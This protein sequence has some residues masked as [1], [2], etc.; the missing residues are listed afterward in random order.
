VSGLV[1]GM[2]NY[3]IID[4]LDSSGNQRD[5]VTYKYNVPSST[6]ATKLSVEGGT[7]KESCENGMFFLFPS[8]GSGISVYDNSGILRDVI[9]TESGKGC[10]IYQSGDC[11]VY[12]VSDTKVAKVSSLGMVLGAVKVKGYGKI[13]D[14][15]YDGYDNIYCLVTKK[16]RDYLVSASFQT[17][18]TKKVYAFPKGVSAGSLSTPIGGSVYVACSKPDGIMK[19]EALTGNKPQVSYILGKKSNWK[20][21]IK[22]NKKLKK[23]VAED[24]T[25]VHWG[26]SKTILN[27]VED[28]SD[29]TK[30]VLTAY[31]TEKGKG[32]G[33]RFTIDGSEKKITVNQSFPT[34]ETGKNLALTY[35]NHF[36]TANLGKGTF[37]E[38]DAEGK[39]VKEYAF[40]SSVSGMTKLSLNDMCFYGGK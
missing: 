35:G 32:T 34:G 17:G 36:L 39:T 24:D 6:A 18:K 9:T 7:S 11:V 40:G 13:R 31:L 29:G 8:K 5:R 33:M 10:R 25:A 15:S 4:V 23:K 2:V 12:S 38:Y 22:K 3:I 21:I 14:F 1:P 26:T 28:S 27:L 16:G 20:K 19:L 37:T 30:D